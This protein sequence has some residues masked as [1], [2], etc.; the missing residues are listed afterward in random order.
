MV[1]QVGHQCEIGTIKN[2]LSFFQIHPFAP[3]PKRA[4]C[5]LFP[6]KTRENF[7]TLEVQLSELLGFL[8]GRCCGILS[9]DKIS[10]LG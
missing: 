3:S 8:H 5:A 2:R 4:Q 9:A 7:T 1:P 6:R 10:K